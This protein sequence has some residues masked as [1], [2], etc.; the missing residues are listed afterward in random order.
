MM[1]T[2]T[3]DR[4]LIRSV[5]VWI[6]LAVASAFPAAVNALGSVEFEAVPSQVTATYDFETETVTTDTITVGS[7]GL[8]FGTYGVGFSAGGS[9]SYD[10]RRLAG[11]GG[12]RMD[13][14][15]MDSVASGNVVKDL[16]GDSTGGG[17][18]TG[19]GSGSSDKTFDLVV[20]QGQLLPPG[21]Y[22]DT[23]TATLYVT[24]Q[25]N[26]VVDQAP[27]GVSV[28]VSPY[29]DLSLVDAGSPFV[30]GQ[31]NVLLDFGPLVQGTTR[32]IELLVRANVNYAVSVDSTNAGVMAQVPPGDG[33][34][35]PYDFTVDGVMHSLS[36][37]SADVAAG[38]GP[39]SLGGTPYLLAFEVGDA[40]GATSGMY[41]DNL[42]ITVTSQ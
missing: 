28:T 38:F 20:P 11:P 16:D 26:A 23:V 36:T 41:E 14:Q 35:V 27:M 42:T 17:L 1:N 32:E 25:N 12:A 37:G 18:L 19:S 9:G 7:T 30:P 15:W 4:G 33:S 13:Y 21:T 24:S 6:L 8:F 10:A 31:D 39:T 22:S 34:T 40:V 5:G 29:I 3:T 2:A